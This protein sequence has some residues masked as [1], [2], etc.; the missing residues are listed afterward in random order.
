M[1]RDS[2]DRVESLFSKNQADNVYDEKCIGKGV[3]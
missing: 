3:N 1:I 2:I